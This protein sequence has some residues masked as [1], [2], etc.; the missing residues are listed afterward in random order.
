M[1]WAQA[2]M[3]R[4]ALTLKSSLTR[5][6]VAVSLLVHNHSEWAGHRRIRDIK[7]SNTTL[8]VNSKAVSDITLQIRHHH[9]IKQRCLVYPSP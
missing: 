6:S 3:G 1:Y 9:I 8:T 2:F 7:W 5:L 4:T